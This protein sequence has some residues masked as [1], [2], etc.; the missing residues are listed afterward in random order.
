MSGGEIVPCGSAVNETTPGTITVNKAVKVSS[1]GVVNF[2]VNASKNSTISA[3]SLT[4]NGTVKVTLVANRELKAGD[5]LKLWTVSGTFSGTPSFD[6]P[7]GYTW[8]TS[9]IS[10]GVIVVTG[11]TGISQIENGKLTMENS[12]YDLN[13][14]LVRRM[15]TASDIKGLPAGIYIR[16][17]KKVVVK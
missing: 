5:E 13:G 11:T 6:L 3:T 8:D 10:E 12:V 14:R 17:G 7:A 9:R 1:D 2:L 4:F 15:S 16:G